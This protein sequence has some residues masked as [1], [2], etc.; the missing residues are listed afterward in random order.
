MT[1]LGATKDRAI[2]DAARNFNLY[3]THIV[4]IIEVRTLVTLTRTEEVAGQRVLGNLR[5]RSRH[6]NRTARH[7]YRTFAFYVGNFVAAIG[8]GQDMTTLDF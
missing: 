2:D 4:V 1:I 8:I 3:T 5:Q 6:A 7:L